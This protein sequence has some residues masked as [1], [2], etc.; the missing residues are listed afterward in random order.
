MKIFKN[1]NPAKLV[2]FFF[3]VVALTCAIAFAASGWQELEQ[4]PNSGKVDAGVIPPTSD[5]SDEDKEDGTVDQE[6]P[7][8]P[9]PKYTHYITG[10]EVSE[11]EYYSKVL[12]ITMSSDAPLYG[13]SDSYLTVEIPTEDGTT[14]FLVLTS[15]ATSHGKIGS[16]APTRKYISNISKYF[17]C[18]LLSHGAD[19]SFEYL[20]HEI[21]N[22]LDLTENSGYHYTEYTEYIYTN[23]D[24]VSALLKNS[25]TP[26]MSSGI[27]SVPYTFTDYYSN[28]VLGKDSAKNV[29]IFFSNGNSTELTYSAED[30]KYTFSKNST[31][32]ND[33]LNDKKTTFD[34]VFILFSD[35]VTYETEEATQTV[36]DTM[37]GGKG[38]YITGGTRINI[39]WGFDSDGNMI[40][41]TE[42]G[43][44]LTINRGTSYLGFVKSSQVSDVVFS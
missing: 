35:S 15:K 39:N 19:D 9:L 42:S 40:Y 31:D 20:G 6:N 28:P 5:E 12:A 33:L 16:I 44:K 26:T 22:H 25:G 8:D 21:K 10:L 34:N 43:E 29:N 7:V 37:G 41:T 38:Y 17:G 14:R 2:A 4:D 3:I 32:K 23:A 18:I 27:P 36:L 24:L 13:I 11:N 1:G 30:N